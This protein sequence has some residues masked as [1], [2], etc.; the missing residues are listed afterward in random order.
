MS[1]EL[2]LDEFLGHRTS[3][4]G[5][6]NFLG[7]WKDRDSKSVDTWLHTRSPIV[8]VWRHAF[9]RLHVLTDKQTKDSVT[10]VWS[11]NYVCH[12]AEDVLRRQ[13]K[14]NDDGTRVAPPTK[15]GACKLIEH[16]RYLVDSNE[17][18]WVDPVFKFEG[19][20]DEVVLNAAGLY[21]GFGADDL[22][23]KQLAE[24]KKHGIYRKDA[25]KQNA[26]A[27]ASYVFRV[28]D[29]DH[30]DKGVQ[31]AV[32]PA[33]LGDK[34]KQ[35]IRDTMD[36]RGTDEGNPMKNPYAIRWQHRPDE[37]E[38]GKKYHAVRMEKLRMTPDIAQL[39][40]ET[41]PPNVDNLTAKHNA[42]S[43]AAMLEKACLIDLPWTKL[44][45]LDGAAAGE[46]E[47]PN[48]DHVTHHGV[49][50]QV[51]AA[52]ESDDEMFACDNCEQPIKASDAKC[53]HCGQEYDV[54]P[55][56]PPPPPKPLP[57]RSA[58]SKA[59]PAPKAAVGGGGTPAKG[60]LKTKPIEPEPSDTGEEDDLP[61]SSC[62]ATR[63]GERW[64]K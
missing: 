30:A 49:R 6:T 39:I 23:D 50:A 32:E 51:P 20:E 17:L 33:L 22:T 35:V 40:R 31:V 15:C 27:K 42:K 59:A 46:E 16:I 57:K 45:D 24:M 61:F 37:K 7:K 54:E 58:A 14:R 12:E 48:D 1:N 26:Y 55:A 56:A 38:F 47:E 11:G 41:D 52:V 28:V 8:V 44:F 13:Y 19:D 18:S 34:V 63:V 2:S 10:K 60:K 25:W 43:L 62:D 36:S 9:P 21:N 64:W 3:G 53:S 29:H 5:N 4:A